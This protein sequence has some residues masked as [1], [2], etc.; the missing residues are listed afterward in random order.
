MSAASRLAA[1]LL[2]APALAAAQSW[3]YRSFKKDPVSG[4]YSRERYVA[5]TITLE[6]RDGKAWF[7]MT[8]AGRGDPCFSRGEL[9]AEV[10]RTAET[11]TITVLP[12]LAGCEPFRYVIRND[13]SGG[14]RQKQREGAWVDDGFD[15]GLTPK[16]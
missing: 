12:P 16:K 1:L 15:H 9:P 13:G 2:L 10:M 8:T 3:E 5:S 11:L 7:R 14:V 4:Q 6:E